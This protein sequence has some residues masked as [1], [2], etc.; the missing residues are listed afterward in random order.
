MT[1]TDPTTEASGMAA[2]SALSPRLTEFQKEVDQLK[3]TGGKANPERTW[4]I[5]G[6]IAMVAGVALTL[7]SWLATRG[8]KSNLDFADYS[9]MGTF[10]IAL[11]IAGTGL[12]LVMS[13]RRYFRYW[14]VRL[15]YEQRDQTDRLLSK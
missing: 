13:L 9:A 2:P 8:T 5:I 3:V 11:T 15:I 1:M 6:G 12:F 14:L 7:I 10:G 4:T